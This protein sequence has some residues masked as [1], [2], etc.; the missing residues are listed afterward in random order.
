MFSF[1]IKYTTYLHV[2]QP[3][4]T[5]YMYIII[6][7]LSKLP[8]VFSTNSEQT[9]FVVVLQSNIICNQLTQ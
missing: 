4:F 7:L 3:L 6:Y 9:G 2:L 5:R 8:I 1:G